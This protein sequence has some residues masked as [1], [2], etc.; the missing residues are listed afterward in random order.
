VSVP[1]NVPGS[2]ELDSPVDV[3]LLPL[4]LFPQYTSYPLATTKLWY[5]PLSLA[6]VKFITPGVLTF[7]HVTSVTVPPISGVI[8]SI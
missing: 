5:V 2:Y 8:V 4:A 3:A 1:L 6:A 7:V